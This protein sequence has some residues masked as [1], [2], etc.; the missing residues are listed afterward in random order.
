MMKSKED[1]SKGC[2]TLYEAQNDVFTGRALSLFCYIPR[3][4]QCHRPTGRRRA[5][6]DPVDGVLVGDAPRF[7]FRHRAIASGGECLVRAHSQRA[8]HQ[9]VFFGNR[10]PVTGQRPH[11]PDVDPDGTG[12]TYFRQGA[13]PDWSQYEATDC[14][15][16]AGFRMS[17]HF[18]AQCGS[19]RYFLSHCRRHA[20][21]LR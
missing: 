9:S 14:G 1:L 18:P 5:G 2:D 21:S 7:H 16:A 8:R 6:T 13:A 17:V 11:L 3:R 20:A 10:G 12:Q 4:R 19:G 15:L